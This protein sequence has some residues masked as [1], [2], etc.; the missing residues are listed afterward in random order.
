MLFVCANL[1]FCGLFLGV[2]TEGDSSYCYVL[3][4]R[5][6]LHFVASF[7]GECVSEPKNK[8]MTKH[9]IHH[10]LAECNDIRF[11]LESFWNSIQF[12]FQKLIT[13]ILS[14]I[15]LFN[16]VDLLYLISIISFVFFF[17]IEWHSPFRHCANIKLYL[18]NN[19]CIFQALPNQMAFSYTYFEIEQ[20]QIKYDCILLHLGRLDRNA[21]YFYYKKFSC[22]V[23]VC[24]MCIKVIPFQWN[25][26]SLQ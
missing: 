10:E 16:V 6:I 3:F 9:E 25:I 20:C 21:N 18:H 15:I 22:N 12:N 4:S 19:N 8:K 17:S 7:I 11:F 26:N 2:D 1:R 14:R 24:A 5:I 23:C 13:D